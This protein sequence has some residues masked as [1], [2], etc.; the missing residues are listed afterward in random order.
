MAK[1][2]DVTSAPLNNSSTNEA[3]IN[4]VFIEGFHALYKVQI[5]QLHTATLFDTGT[6]I[7]MF[8]FK[9]YSKIQHQLKILPTS[10]NVVSA[11]SNSLGPIGEVHLKFKIDKVVFNERF[12][13]FEQPT[14]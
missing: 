14:V 11:D 8:L 6:S 10:R 3:I 12:V 13:I 5:G 7:N 9:F 2:S 1:D 4:K